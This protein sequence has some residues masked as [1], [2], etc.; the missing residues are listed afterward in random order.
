MTYF[1]VIFLFDLNIAKFTQSVLCLKVDSF[2]SRKTQ[3]NREKHKKNTRSFFFFH[4]TQLKAQ[5]QKVN[6]PSIHKYAS[7]QSTKRTLE[8]ILLDAKFLS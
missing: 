3:N 5:I 8:L 2:K 1:R 6:H 7:A 4:H